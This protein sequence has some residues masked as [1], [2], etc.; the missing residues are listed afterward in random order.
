MP[1]D[2][3][4]DLGESS[5]P[6]QLESDARL[7]DSVSSVNIAC[8]F[9]AGGPELMRHTVRLAKEK[10]VAVGA[11]PGFRDPEG[12]G[13]RAMVMPPGELE[14]LVAYQVGALAGIAALEGTWL[15]HVK[16]HGALYNLAAQSSEVAEAV[17]R[18]VAAIDS[19]LVLVGLAGSQLIAAARTMGLTGAQEAF[20]DRAYHPD[21]TLV[22]RE[23]QGAVID[24]EGEVVTR[25]LSIARE[26]HVLSWDGQRIQ[27]HADTICVHGDTPGADR[28]ARSIK[29]ALLDAGI[30]I[31]A[32]GTSHA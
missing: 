4:C 19:Q 6:N 10:G 3:N 7:L 12:L 16:P 11:H 23:R 28:L 21:G 31:V 8:G 18:A 26:G 32:L 17:A 20:A 27:V 25:A 29:Q 24:D 22:G 5:E 9:H 13:R 30:R 2:L 14:D 1:I 15:S